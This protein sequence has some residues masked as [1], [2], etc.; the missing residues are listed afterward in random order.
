MEKT[1]LEKK[2]KEKRELEFIMFCLAIICGC[3]LLITMLRTSLYCWRMGAEGES[4]LSPFTEV[5]PYFVTLAVMSVCS[6]IIFLMLYRVHKGQVFT[7]QNANLVILIG[8]L[9]EV[10]GV[11]QQI[12]YLFADEDRLVDSVYLIYILLG[13]FFLFVGCL[14]KMGVHIREEQELTI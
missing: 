7:M 3:C 9:V 4:T 12:Y 14:F 2:Q 1:A 5:L 11:F 10:N 8:M 13:V 6:L